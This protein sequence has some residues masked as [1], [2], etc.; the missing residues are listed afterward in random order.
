MGIYIL[1]SNL[2]RLFIL[3][4][5]ENKVYCTLLVSIIILSLQPYQTDTFATFST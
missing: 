5:A 1:L 3:T 2:N 4:A